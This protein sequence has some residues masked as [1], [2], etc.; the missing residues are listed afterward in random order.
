M[1]ARLTLLLAARCAALPASDLSEALQPA[2]AG[3]CSDDDEFSDENSLT[4]GDY[5][6]HY[7]ECH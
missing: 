7:C 5:V 6:P 1:I 4:C 2:A 3:S